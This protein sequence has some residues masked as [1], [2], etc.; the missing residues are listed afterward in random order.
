MASSAEEDRNRE[1]VRHVYEASFGGDA[2]AFRAAMHEDFE[3][4]VPPVLPWGGVHRGPDA[5]LRDVL[6][7]FGAAVDFASIR[8]VSLSADGEH[9]AALLTARSVGGDEL[10]IAEHWVLRDGK[11]WRMRNF[12][13]DTTPLQKLST[14]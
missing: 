2:N 6:P 5:Y 9:V 12:Y 1:I 8:L 7:K 3:E 13:F 14:P 4:S 11:L 10:W